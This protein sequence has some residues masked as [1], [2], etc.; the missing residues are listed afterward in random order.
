MYHRPLY[1]GEIGAPVKAVEHFDD[2]E[3][4]DR[5]LGVSPSSRIGA[6]TP[7][8]RVLNQ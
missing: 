2:R 5:R 8:R 1:Q 7:I 6:K 3:P 4:V